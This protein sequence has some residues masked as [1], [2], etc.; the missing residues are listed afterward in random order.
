MIRKKEYLKM[1]KLDST[2]KGA[3][4]VKQRLLTVLKYQESTRDKEEVKESRPTPMT[5]FG[6]RREEKVQRQYS[7]KDEQQE[8]KGFMGLFTGIKSYF[9]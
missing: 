1:Y 7:N 3:I 2:V 6:P 5:Y 8:K 9:K 4:E